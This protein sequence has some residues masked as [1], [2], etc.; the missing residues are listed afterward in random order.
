[1]QHFVTAEKKNSYTPQHSAII[2][3]GLFWGV[4][5]IR[6]QRAGIFQNLDPLSVPES[7]VH[8]SA[9]TK[10]SGNMSWVLTSIW[11]QVNMTCGK[12]YRIPWLTNAVC[13]PKCVS[14]D[15]WAL[16]WEEKMDIENSPFKGL[17]ARPAST[18]EFSRLNYL[19]HLVQWKL[20]VL[21]CSKIFR[22]PVREIQ[23]RE[24]FSLLWHPWAQGK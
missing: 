2:V 6:P 5:A 11:M 17:L 24:E 23:F 19:W 8:C 20:L 4:E 7:P 1:M 18:L 21:V 9:P 15:F 13:F 22:S 16:I 12:L 14:W 10:P 3:V